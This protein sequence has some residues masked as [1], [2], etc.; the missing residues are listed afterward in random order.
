MTQCGVA[1]C[2]AHQRDLS[3]YQS[4]HLHSPLRGQKAPGHAI[5]DVGIECNRQLACRCSLLRGCIRIL[6]PSPDF[7]LYC[8]RT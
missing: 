3:R 1:P 4:Y 2:V 5:I 8:L 6:L 7:I